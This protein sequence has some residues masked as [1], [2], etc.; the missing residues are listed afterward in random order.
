MKR[1]RLEFVFCLRNYFCKDAFASGEVCQCKASRANSLSPSLH[2]LLVRT[3]ET[4]RHGTGGGTGR[5]GSGSNHNHKQHT[6]KR[7]GVGLLQDVV[8]YPRTVVGGRRRQYGFQPLE[9]TTSFSSP[10]SYSSTAPLIP[11]ATPRPRPRVERR[12]ERVHERGQERGHERHEPTYEDIHEAFAVYEPGKGVAHHRRRLQLQRAHRVELSIEPGQSL[13]LM[14]RG[15]VEYNLGVFITGVDK[16][17]V[18]DRAGLAIGDQILEV[19][20][21]SFLDV[22]HDE[23][24][25]QLKLHKRMTL[26]VRDVGKVPHSCSD[27]PPRPWDSPGRGFLG[28]SGRSPALQMVE[29]KARV[30]LTK[31]EFATLAYY[32]EE[33][34][35]GQMTIEAFVAVLLELLNTPEKYTL[36]TELREVV[37]PEDRA[38]FDE[39][40]YRREVE[41]RR[42][43]T[44]PDSLGGAA[45]V[46]AGAACCDVDL[47][48]FKTPLSEDSGLGLGADYPRS[49]RGWPSMPG[50]H[51]T[52]DFSEEDMLQEYGSLEREKLR[53]RRHSSPENSLSGSITGLQK[54]GFDDSRMP[55][56]FDGLRSHLG[57]WTQ[58]VKSWY[59]GSPLLS[60][61][62]AR[63]T[64]APPQLPHKMGRSFEL[65]DDQELLESDA[66]GMRR[67]HSMQRLGLHD[68][69]AE[70]AMVVA[71]QLGNLRITVRKTKPLLGIAIEGGA[72]TKHPLPRIINIHEHGAAYEAGGLEVGQLILEVDGHRVEA[73]HHQ[74]IARMIAESFARRDRSEIEFLVIEAK[75]SNLEPKPTALIFLEG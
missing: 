42:C 57:G 54:D 12:H 32:Q 44:R 34:A 1:P 22:T 55:G 56:Y 10:E 70:A 49:K 73:M 2:Y 27:P 18:A 61:Q 14:I 66:P 7:D 59:W 4:V 33:Y 11:V 74:D 30:V 50:P 23:A 38:R 63:P 21:Q 26:T 46:A 24:V 41:G 67:H 13:G 48:E 71:D 64:S 9:E 25:A 3:K 6:H 31:T 15:G 5:A 28:G 35:A 37:V 52:S 43:V 51:H 39:L 72:N 29:E 69:E 65:K 58:K 40:V 68:R 20:G 62:E 45:A 17:S 75:K 60:F 8:T 47:L 19:N 36:L 16:D 53:G